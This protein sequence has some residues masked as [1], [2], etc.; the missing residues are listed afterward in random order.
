MT[1]SFTTQAS[2]SKGRLRY[3]VLARK[4]LNAGAQAASE[5]K[6]RLRRNAG[7]QN[8]EAQETKPLFPLFPRSELP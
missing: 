4:H 6:R 5:L 3:C 2:A 1:F 7:A 8:A